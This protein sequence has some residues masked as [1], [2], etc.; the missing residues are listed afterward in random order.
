MKFLTSVLCLLCVDKV[1][2][3]EDIVN[4]KNVKED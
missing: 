4:L 3:K 2:L 1:E